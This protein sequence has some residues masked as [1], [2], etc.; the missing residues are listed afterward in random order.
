[1]MRSAPMVQLARRMIL[2]RR[3]QHA[4]KR[5]AHDKP[6]VESCMGVPKNT[7]EAGAFHLKPAKEGN[8]G[9]PARLNRAQAERKA[10]N[11]SQRCK[12][13]LPRRP[14][15][16]LQQPVTLETCRSFAGKTATWR[17]FTSRV[18]RRISIVGPGPEPQDRLVIPLRLSQM[19]YSSIL[20]LSLGLL[21]GV[22]SAG[23]NTEA[24]IGGALGGVLGS[25]VG[26][27]IGGST[28]SAIGAGLGGAAGSAVGANKHSRGEAAI[29]GALG[30]AGG[31]V[32][33]RKMGGTTGSMIGA[34]AGGGVGGALGN[35][36]GRDYDDES[37]HRYRD[38]DDDDDDR[39][40]RRHRH[41]RGHHYGWRKHRYD[42]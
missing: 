32:V 34:A 13:A 10:M 11:K 21:S 3:N 14:R 4:R 16:L 36:M 20:L 5:S 39:G 9:C 41:D 2:L 31:N 40:W 30:A 17:I 7:G 19:K 8:V 25:V 33:G 38:Y 26:Q 29:G 24:G 12:Q 15:C 27:S 6:A 23:G 42:D 1:M 37:G 22:A 18:I 28:G 35:H